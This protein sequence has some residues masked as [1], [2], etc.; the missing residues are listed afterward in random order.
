[1]KSRFLVIFLCLVLGVVSVGAQGVAIKTNLLY[2]LTATV[3]AGVEVG[4]SPKWTLDVSGNYN[5]WTLSN[6]RKWKHWLVQPEARYW[7]CDRFAGHFLGFHLLGG[8][9]NIG[10]L[11]NGLKFLGTDFSQ[12]SDHRFQGW[13]AGAGVAY[14]YTWVLGRY[15]NLEAEIGLGYIYSRYDKFECAGCGQKTETGQ[16]HHYLGPTKAA[17][18]LIYVF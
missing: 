17:V 4:L 11:K 9:Y 3:N 12:L 18:N 5:A 14:G 7:F 15:W 1:M 2:D 10:G 13:M 16:P 8:Q 6:D